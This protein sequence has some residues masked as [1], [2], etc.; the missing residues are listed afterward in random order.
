MNMFDRARAIKSTMELCNMTQSMMAR[1]L[2]V[3]QSCV[4]NKLRLLNLSDECQKIITEHGLCEKIA[5]SVLR[6][7]S[8]EK[9]QSVLHTVCQR[10]LT[11]RECEA[12]VS[13]IVDAEA[14]RILC[15]ASELERI[16]AFRNT[17]KECVNNLVSAG[18]SASLKTTYLGEK[19]FLT[20]CIDKA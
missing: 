8:D 9:R 16:S 15:R 13:L 3:T 5:R 7:E 18:V 11:A 17:L 10:G 6:I 20:V 14:P 12:Q 19:M 1:Q 4:A 2:G